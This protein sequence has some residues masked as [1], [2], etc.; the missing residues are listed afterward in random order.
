MSELTVLAG[1]LD[2]ATEG[3]LVVRH[4]L[5]HAVLSADAAMS[6]LYTARCTG[7]TPRARYSAGMVQLSFPLIELRGRTHT[8][9]ITLNGS[10]PWAIEIVGG[11]A[12]V[13]ADLTGVPVRSIDIDGGTARTSLELSHP[14]GT[15]PVRLGAVADTTIRR[16][17]GV[18][19]RVRIRRGARSITVDD[20]TVAASTGPTTLTSPGYDRA[21]DRVDVSVD[22]AE[23]L[24]VTATD[25]RVLTNAGPGEVMLAANTWLARFGAA[26]VSWP[27]VERAVSGNWS[28]A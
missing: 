10:I 22:N 26:G 12:D 19:V 3:R 23:R 13:R 21:T 18:P 17:A 4:G 6:E 28:A 14:D 8:D 27:A 2:G 11:V 9:M 16:P 24:S 25:L 15:V 1:P 20:Q 5:D 7:R